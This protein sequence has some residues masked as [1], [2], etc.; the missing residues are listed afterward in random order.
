MYGKTVP[1]SGFS[2]DDGSAHREVTEALA[3]YRAGRLGKSELVEALTNRRLMAAVV[4]TVLGE[5]PVAARAGGEPAPRRGEREP[6]TGGVED[7]SVAAGPPA[8]PGVARVGVEPRAGR[9]SPSEKAVEVMLITIKG[10]DGRIALPA[11]TSLDALSR[12]KAGARPVP[13]STQRVC[14]GA[15]SEGADLVVIDPAGPATVELSG[16]VLWARAEGRAMAPL[17]DDPA[18][19]GAIRDATEDM[20]RAFSGTFLQPGADQ[21]TDLVIQ[22]VARAGADPAELRDAAAE[23]ASRL[24]ADPIMRSRVDGGVQIAVVN[25]P[26]LRGLQV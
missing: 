5:E 10:S 24:A 20:A 3:A 9:A 19:I 22:L 12:W 15:L 18:V 21:S 25:T 2:G 13:A 26:P 16:A 7:R 11:F 23:L 6:L 14:A 1:D 17:A 4:T 8:E